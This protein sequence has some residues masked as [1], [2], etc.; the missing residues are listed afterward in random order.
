M[1]LQYSILSFF[2]CVLISVGRYRVKIFNP[3]F[4]I[5]LKIWNV[6]AVYN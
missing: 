2:D 6:M 4:E 1:T 3:K 5:Q